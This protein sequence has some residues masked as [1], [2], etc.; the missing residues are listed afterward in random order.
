MKGTN[1]GMKTIR[2]GEL[3]AK[4]TIKMI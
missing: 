4:K 3:K 2:L 1:A